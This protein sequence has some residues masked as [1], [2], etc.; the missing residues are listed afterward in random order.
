MT[1]RITRIPFKE[2]LQPFP[3]RRGLNV[4]PSHPNYVIRDSYDVPLEKDLEILQASREVF[5][6][7]QSYGISVVPH[8]FVLGSE[9]R[10]HHTIFTIAD[11]VEGEDFQN[12]TI[13][14]KEADRFLANICTFYLILTRTAGITCLIWLIRLNTYG[15][16]LREIAKKNLF[17]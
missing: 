10:R 4:L 8:Q 14:T 17:R 2:E 13:P 7:M 16:I 11:K 9:N 3:K 15:A 1:E 5:S 12:A 6:R